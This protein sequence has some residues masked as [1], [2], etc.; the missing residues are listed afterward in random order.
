MREIELSAVRLEDVEF[1]YP[2]VGLNLPVSK[3]EPEGRGA[4][5]T[6]RCACHLEAG[7]AV[8]PYHVVK[9][10][11]D[12]AKGLAVAA[13]RGADRGSRAWEKRPLCP[14]ASGG[15]FTKRGFAAALGQFPLRRLVLR[16][17]RRLR[18]ENGYPRRAQDSQIAI[19]P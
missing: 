2:L 13:F 9:A 17:R 16:Q 14:A 12:F 10:Q 3:K 11:Y 6:H 1:A 19:F 7:P 8:C 18:R 15:G 5:R 4:K